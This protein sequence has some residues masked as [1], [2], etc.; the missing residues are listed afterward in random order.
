VRRSVNGHVA[1]AGRF[2]TGNPEVRTDRHSSSDGE[3]PYRAGPSNRFPPILETFRI[4][5]PSD[6]E[7]V[8]H[9]LELPRL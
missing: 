4:D 1:I 3:L 7:N 5:E 6:V 2:W 9:G 8:F